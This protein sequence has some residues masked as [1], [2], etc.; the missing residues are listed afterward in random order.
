MR[1][2]SFLLFTEAEIGTILTDNVLATDTDTHSDVAFE[3]VPDVRLESNW[4]RHFFSAQFV[5]DRSWYRDFEVED[6]RIY[7]A[8]LKGR[9]D[10]TRRTHLELE[11]EKSMTQAGRNS[12]E[13]DRYRRQSDRPEGAAS[14]CRRRSHFNRLTSEVSGTVAQYDYD[15]EPEPI[16]TCSV[17]TRCLSSISGTIARTS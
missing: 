17:R 1:F 7:Q 2:G 9:L 4:G 3:V 12:V 8:T 6:D 16:P 10:V 5:A 15:D 11:A 13:P 14:D